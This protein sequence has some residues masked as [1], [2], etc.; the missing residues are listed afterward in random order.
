[1]PFNSVLV[2]IRASL[3]VKEKQILRHSFLLMTIGMFGEQVKA[4]PAGKGFA[5]HR[6][7]GLQ[8]DEIPCL[9]PGWDNL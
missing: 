2:L 9:S 4:G 6:P 7:A 3:E 1:L 8:H 5:R